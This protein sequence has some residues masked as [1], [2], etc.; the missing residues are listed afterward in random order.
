MGTNQAYRCRPRAPARGELFRT[1][2]RAN[3]VDEVTLQIHP[4]VLGSGL[5]RF[6]EDDG[7][8][9]LD[10][11]GSSTTSTRVAVATYRRT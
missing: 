5:R 3:L 9:K 10:L 8:A 11:A 1:L 2:L 7:L 6:G 4:L